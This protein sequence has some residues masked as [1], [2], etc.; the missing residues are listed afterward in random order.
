MPIGVYIYLNYL[1]SWNSSLI[2]GIEVTKGLLPLNVLKCHFLG[3]LCIIRFLCIK[4]LTF[5]EET[6][7]ESQVR[8][9]SRVATVF[10]GL[11]VCA[12]FFS[13]GEMKTFTPFFLMTNHMV[14]P[15]KALFIQLLSVVLSNLK[16][17]SRWV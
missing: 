11:A 12:A 3:C 1:G 8:R 4:N 15:S 13:F 16:P 7:T 14:F 5:M 10:S 9:I 2:I 6:V 17:S